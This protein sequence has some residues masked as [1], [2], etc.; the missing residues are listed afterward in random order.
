MRSK[1]TTESLPQG[2]CLRAAARQ[3]DREETA[4]T[5]CAHQLDLRGCRRVSSARVRWGD[6]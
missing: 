3:G 6:G 2:L 1:E 5:M 4:S